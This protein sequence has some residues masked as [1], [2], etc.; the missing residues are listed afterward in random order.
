VSITL[1]DVLLVPEAPY[2]LLSQNAVQDRGINTE[3]HTKGKTTRLLYDS[4]VVRRNA[5]ALSGLPVIKM[6]ARK[7]QLVAVA[8]AAPRRK[9]SAA[10]PWH[11]RFGHLSYNTLARTA[12]YGSVKGLIASE[13]AFR[14]IASEM[15]DS[16]VMAKHVADSHPQ[17]QSRATQPL[18]LVHSD[19]MGP[20]R[21]QSAG[22]KK[23]VLTAIDDFSGL[24]AIKALKHKSQATKQLKVILIAWERATDKL[25]KTVRTDRGI[26]YNV[27]ECEDEGIRRDKSVAYTPQQNGRAERFNRIGTLRPHHV[28][29]SEGDVSHNHVK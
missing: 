6:W 13:K 27:L 23:Y 3:A 20:F 12:K 14:E 9:L 25:V 8:V 22:G 29:A 24:A 18:E 16:C 17:S 19:L 21:P 4:H 5:Y 11:G 2:N 26:E 10:E 7:M 15:C 28:T 1:H